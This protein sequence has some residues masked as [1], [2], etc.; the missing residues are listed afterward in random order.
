MINL[1]MNASSTQL[2]RAFAVTTIANVLIKQ[3]NLFLGEWRIEKY[4][5]SEEN[6]EESNQI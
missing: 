3:H 1:E 6:I 4:V 5:C 2:L